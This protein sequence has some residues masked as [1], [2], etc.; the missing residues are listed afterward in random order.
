MTGR[1]DPN[2]GEPYGTCVDCDAKFDTA[3]DARI[4]MTE[5]MLA[6]RSASSHTVRATNPPREQRIRAEVA[7]RISSAIDDAFQDL[8]RLV[9]RGDLTP[10]EVKTALRYSGPSDL[11]DDWDEWLGDDR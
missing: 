4:H 6:A 8:E 3:D 9:D 2:P 1:F 5:T 11:E 10:D 7:S